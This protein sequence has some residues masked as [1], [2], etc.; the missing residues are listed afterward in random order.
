MSEEKEN[1]E[2]I[3]IRGVNK[4]LYQKLSAYAKEAGMTVGEAI[5]NAMASF[6]A[7]LEGI[8]TTGR[9]LIE[10]IQKGMNI[11]IGDIDELKIEARDLN[12]VEN[13]VILRN[14]KR[15]E[16]AEDVDQELFNKKIRRIV[17]V[18][19][20]IIHDKLSKFQV[21]AKSFRIKKLTVKKTG[22]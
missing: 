18:D 2:I 15:L 19:E 22:E 6:L 1:K 16:I 11:Y 9:E 5:N 13:P 20:L 8:R 3:S 14:I 17:N 10:G 4:D 7:T 12:E 21:L